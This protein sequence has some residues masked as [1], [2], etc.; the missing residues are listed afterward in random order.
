MAA[1]F[2][3][4]HNFLW[5]ALILF[6]G[7]GPVLSQAVIDESDANVLLGE[8]QRSPENY[9]GKSVLFG[10]TIVRAGN[11]S[12]GS[13]V[14]ILQR[15]LGYRLEPKLNDQT[16]GRLLLKT[17]EI[18]DEQ[19]FAKGRKITLVG[20]VEG[21]ETRSLDEITYDYPILRVREYYL[22]PEGRAR[23]GPNVNFSFGLFG[24]F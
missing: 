19:I 23:T 24:S 5:L 21:K 11:D 7:C 16:G 20:Q 2:K 15:P 18:W 6:S 10:G 8:L 3:T 12:S 14:E 17:N 1:I 22:W 9:L 4:N 13:W